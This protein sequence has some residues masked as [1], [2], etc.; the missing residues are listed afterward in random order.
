MGI[1]LPQKENQ[2][3]FLLCNV[4]SASTD[5]PRQGNIK[6]GDIILVYGFYPPV[7]SRYICY[8]I[9]A[10]IIEEADSKLMNYNEQIALKSAKKGMK[11]Q[12]SDS[13]LYVTDHR[14]VSNMAPNYERTVDS[15]GIFNKKKTLYVELLEMTNYVREKFVGVGNSNVHCETLIELYNEIYYEEPNKQIEEARGVSVGEK[16]ILDTFYSNSSARKLD[17][18]EFF[19]I[20][21]LPSFLKDEL[22]GDLDVLKKLQ[23]LKKWFDGLY[24]NYYDCQKFGIT[25]L[26]DINSKTFIRNMFLVCTIN[27]LW[28]VIFTNENLQKKTIKVD[29]RLLSGGVEDQLVRIKD[30]NQKIPIFENIEKFQEC[31]NDMVQ[32]NVV[33]R[34]KASLFRAA[35][36][37]GLKITKKMYQLQTDQLF[38]DISSIPYSDSGNLGTDFYLKMHYLLTSE[39]YSLDGSGELIKNEKMI[40]FKNLPPLIYNGT[41]KSY[42]LREQHLAKN[43]IIGVIKNRGCEREQCVQKPISKNGKH[44]EDL[45]TVIN[46][47]KNRLKEP[48]INSSS[49]NHGDLDLPLP[50]LPPLNNSQM[51]ILNAI[52]SNFI[53]CVSGDPGTGKSFII[54]KIIE[55]YGDKAAVLTLTGNAAGLLKRQQEKRYKNNVQITH[56]AYLEHL[57]KTLPRENDIKIVIIEEASMMDNKSLAMAFSIYPNKTKIILVGNEKQIGPADLGNPYSQLKMRSELYSNDDRETE[58]SETD[59]EETEIGFHTLTRNMRRMT[60]GDGGGGDEKNI[61]KFQ[62]SYM[63]DADFSKMDINEVFPPPDDSLSIVIKK[64]GMDNEKALVEQFKTKLLEGNRSIVALS[65]K[66]DNVQTLNKLINEEMIKTKFKKITKKM[67]SLSVYFVG[68][69]VLVNLYGKEF[70]IVDEKTTAEIYSGETYTVKKIQFYNQRS[71]KKEL[72][73]YPTDSTSQTLPAVQ[74]VNTKHKK[75]YCKNADY[76]YT[77]TTHI[78]VLTVSNQGGEDKIFIL[79]QQSRAAGVKDLVKT[80]TKMFILKIDQVIPGWSITINKSENYE[81][82]HVYLYIPETTD[83]CS[84]ISNGHGLVAISRAK[85]SLKVFCDNLTVFNNIKQNVKSCH[86]NLLD[87]LN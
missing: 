65:F 24:F 82:D 45:K 66:R 86:S 50:P 67:K 27:P 74:I 2:K 85:K 35:Y 23:F 18:S 64:E 32:L 76:S 3:P 84:Q 10:E 29:F 57:R 31:L 22:V 40:H 54:A 68:Q 6:R 4:F 13:K 17:G 87:L 58:P 28:F 71:K 60:I 47:Q 42:E 8:K 81:Y 69:H 48:K 36:T 49:D 12:S 83:D 52:D 70:S 15:R 62:R 56:V 43:I 21:R 25:M 72:P 51:N 46:I 55:K 33:S 39:K 63:N 61:S 11:T 34:E 53:T 73:N 14:I 30:T 26:S 9:K 20:A 5:T 7:F 79:D 41:I 78:I 37:V 80:K 19:P 1:V 44:K 75:Y 38:L 16:W 77:E 59:H